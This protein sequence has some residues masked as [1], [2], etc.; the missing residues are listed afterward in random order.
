MFADI[1]QKIN[2]I[3]KYTI[4]VLFGWLFF[5][6]LSYLIPKKKNLVVFVGRIEG[7]FMGNVKYLFLYLFRTKPK[8]LEYHFLTIH[9]DIYRELKRYRMPIIPYPNIITTFNISFR[10]MYSILLLLRASIVIVDSLIWTHHMRYH[11]LYNSFKIQLWHGIPLKK[12]ELQAYKP[13]L[14]DKIEGR[15]PEYDTVL[16][17]SEFNT[18]NSFSRAFNS[19]EIIED[20]YPTNDVFFR[21]VD[22][23][24]LLGTDLKSYQKIIKF[25]ENGYKTILYAPTFRDTGGD[26]LQDKVIDLIK[27]NSFAKYNKM[28]FIFKFHP[29]PSYKFNIDNF[30]Y[31]IKYDNQKDVYPLLNQID[32]LLTDYSSI[33][34]DFLLISNPIVFS[35]MISKNI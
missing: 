30:D 23:L 7:M 32:L 3:I 16:S 11:I 6:P 15:Y 21:D 31:L 5:I 19:K 9:D 25:I 34:F 24:D 14:L 27:L 2:S 1:I 13:S 33:Y 20:G 18:K 8:N 29:Y 17:T 4:L 22:E 28:I 35:P 12:I 26:A 10:S